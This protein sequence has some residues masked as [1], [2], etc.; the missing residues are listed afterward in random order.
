[1]LSTLT[2]TPVPDTIQVS[3]LFRS[4]FASENVVTA[5]ASVLVSGHLVFTANR[6]DAGPGPAAG[7]VVANSSLY[8]AN[9]APTADLPLFVVSSQHDAAANLLTITFI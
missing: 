1:M 5:G 6:F 2:P 9:S 7:F 8:T 4:I 3:G